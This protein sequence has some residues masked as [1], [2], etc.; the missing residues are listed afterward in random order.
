[1]SQNVVIDFSFKLIKFFNDPN[2][3]IFQAMNGLSIPGHTFG[4]G[5]DKSD[6]IYA[7]EGNI[8]SIKYAKYLS[9]AL[10]R[11]VPV[12]RFIMPRDMMSAPEKNRNNKCLCTTPYN[13]ELCQGMVDLG[14]CTFGAPISLTYP[15]FL[16]AS[17]K[18]RQTVFGLEPIADKHQPY[19]D[20]H[21]T[22]GLPINAMVRLQVNLLIEPLSQLVGFGDLS[23]AILPFLWFEPEI[24]F[25]GVMAYLP[26]LGLYPL[27]ALDY[28]AFGIMFM[29]LALIVLARL[30]AHNKRNILSS[31]SAPPQPVRPVQRSPE[32]INSNVRNIDNNNNINNNN[33]IYPI[34]TI[35]DK[36]LPFSS[37][38]SAKI[39]DDTDAV[40]A[41]QWSRPPAYSSPSEKY[42]VKRAHFGTQ[43]SP[44]NVGR[45]LTSADRKREVQSPPGSI[46]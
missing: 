14:P 10:S 38:K 23:E 16:H 32:L 31:P 22:L 2:C 35:S 26:A 46:Q 4:P 8:C 17:H 30:Y 36:V 13:P 42:Y 19:L 1:M 41:D 15:H 28:G 11:Y 40:S 29:G 39:T 25:D 43:T 5:A 34:T 6:K 37:E 18:I 33:N 20:V 24:H 27:M 12:W 9:Y 45:R 44:L 3:R 7:F 21:P